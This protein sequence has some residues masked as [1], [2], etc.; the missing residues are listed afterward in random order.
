MHLP[1]LGRRTVT[2][3]TRTA[4]ITVAVV[5]V[6]IAVLAFGSSSVRTVPLAAFL[7]IVVTIWFCAQALTALLL[8]GQ[9]YVTGAIGFVLF[10]SAYE[11][12]AILAVPYL[13]GVPGVVSNA[14]PSLAGEQSTVW[15]WLLWH[16]A[17][18]ALIVLG[19]GLDPLLERKTMGS[20]GEIGSSLAFTAIATFVGAAI[21]ALIVWSARG[22]LSEMVIAGRSTPLFRYGAA[23]LVALANAGACA[24]VFVRGKR[25]T[26]LGIWIA[27]ALFAAALEGAIAAFSES[28]FSLAWYLANVETTLTAGLVLAMLLLEIG[29]L[30]GRL[31]DLATRDALTGLYNRR[32]LD[33]YLHW[34]FEYASRRELG[35]ALLVVDIDHFKRYNDRYGHASGDVALRRV[36]AVLRKSAVRR[37]DLVA[38]YGGEEFVIALF[39]VGP[40]QAAVVAERLKQRI[41]AA[42]IPHAAVDSG[43]L[44][45]SIGVGQVGDAASSTVEELFAAADRALYQ[46]K[47]AGRDRYMLATIG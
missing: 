24:F 18:P 34:A 13:F 41:D 46:A 30:Y 42:S 3:A 10:A 43:R 7:P 4:A 29:L 25:A 16:L 23:P 39:N 2:A 31:S 26:S 14:A 37:Y 44:S 40:H 47:A 28:T 1:D 21:V 8:F 17:F 6:V 36:A 15:L 33:D 32:V 20:R 35:L 5:L 38:R 27:L 12:A 9:Y 19:F 45:V 11:F 22:A